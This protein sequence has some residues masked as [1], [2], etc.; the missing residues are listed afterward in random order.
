MTTYMPDLLTEVGVTRREADVLAALALR[1]TNAEIAERLIVSTRTV[2][3]HVS[4][5]L[6]KL[7]AANRRQLGEIA[8][9]SLAPG[10][11]RSLLRRP[12][13]RA[14]TW[15]P[16]TPSPCRRRSERVRRCVV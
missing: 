5:L 12:S 6:R 1:L 10:V 8:A 4:S 14:C 3:S 16:A 2:E 13:P 7:Q 9:S 11:I 15:I